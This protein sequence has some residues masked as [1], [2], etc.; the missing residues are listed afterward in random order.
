MSSIA[1]NS[2]QE[3][4]LSKKGHYLLSGYQYHSVDYDF[5]YYLMFVEYNGQNHI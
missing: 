3:N 2:L 1:S 5:L 4:K